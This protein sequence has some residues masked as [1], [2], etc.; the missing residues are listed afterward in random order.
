MPGDR[1]AKA[2]DRIFPPFDSSFP[3]LNFYFL[4]LAFRA[5]RS[6][7]IKKRARPRKLSQISEYTKLRKIR[8]SRAI[9][10]HYFHTVHPPL[11]FIKNVHSKKRRRK[12]KGR[13]RRRKRDIEVYARKGRKKEILRNLIKDFSSSAFFYPILF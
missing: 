7:L 10:F 9:L 13:E 3:R 5:L 4:A 2:T 6:L 12:G 1:A 8:L 11:P